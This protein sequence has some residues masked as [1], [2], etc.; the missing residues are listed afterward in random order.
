M[1][2]DIILIYLCGLYSLGFA[3]FHLLFWRLFDWKNDLKKLTIA[4]KA[5]IQIANT[6]LIY[7]FMF[8]AF[9]C[10]YCTKELVETRLGNIFLIGISIFWLGRT[11]EQF[12]FLSVKNRMV[13]ILTFIFAIGTILFVLPLLSSKCFYLIDN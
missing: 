7:F 4:N 1:T 13:N 3:I 8:V 6:R 11:I 2:T 9:V 12:I 5:I 10:F